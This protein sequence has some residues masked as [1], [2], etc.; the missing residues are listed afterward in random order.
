MVLI[1]IE[2]CPQY[3]ESIIEF[4]AYYFLW[5][6]E[7][8]SF[9][10]AL[11]VLAIIATIIFII[12]VNICKHNEKLPN[13]QILPSTTTPKTELNILSRDLKDTYQ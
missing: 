1:E 12:I 8:S 10:M 13:D 7:K 11:I 9:E 4:F 2:P 6:V 3:I 5:L